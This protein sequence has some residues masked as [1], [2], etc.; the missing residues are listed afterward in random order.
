MSRRNPPQL[1]NA[2]IYFSFSGFFLFMVTRSLVNGHFLWSERR[3]SPGTHTVV[4]PETHPFF[5][6]G[7]LGFWTLI[8][9]WIGYLG[10]KEIRALRKQREA[11]R[12]RS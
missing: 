12:R 2:L 6:W 1:A 10:W 3:R 4:S 8:L 7:W 5:Y 11:R 9:L